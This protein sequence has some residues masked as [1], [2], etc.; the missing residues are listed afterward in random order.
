M[1]ELDQHIV[2]EQHGSRQ[3]GV[4]SAEFLIELAEHLKEEDRFS[5][6]GRGL[7]G[8]RERRMPVDFSGSNR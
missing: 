7:A 1:Y 2:G 8:V 4:R 6:F 3:A 5:G